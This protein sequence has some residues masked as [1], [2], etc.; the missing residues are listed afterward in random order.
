MKGKRKIILALALMLVFSTVVFAA[1]KVNITVTYD[2]VKVVVDGRQVQFGKDSKGKQIEPFIYNGTTY[3]P[4]RAVAEALGKEVQWDKNTKTAFLGDAYPDNNIDQIIAEDKYLID[5]I[6]PY[7]ENNVTTYREGKEKGLSFSFWGNP[8]PSISYNLEG[9]YTKITAIQGLSHGTDMPITVKFIGDGR[10]LEEYTIEGN[11]MPDALD[12][13][14]TG[15]RNLNIQCFR[16]EGNV[17]LRL[18]MLDL[19]IR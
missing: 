3:L 11:V 16:D 15:V 5:V 1:R 12:V 18:R 7:A 2:N 14:V 4:L 8:C 13:D 17:T 9:K 19:K 10:L 6:K